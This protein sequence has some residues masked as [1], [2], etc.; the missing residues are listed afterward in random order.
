[1]D[2]GIDLFTSSGASSYNSFQVR[3]EKRFS[4]GL[5]FQLA[6]TWAHSIDNAS[7]ANLG[8]T[9]NNSDFRDFRHPEAEFGNSD[10]DVRHRFTLGYIY[11]LPF[12]NG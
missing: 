11:E 1:V 3:Y 2:S 5:Q 7:N 4:H 12:G 10:F 9:Q 8:P 6:Y